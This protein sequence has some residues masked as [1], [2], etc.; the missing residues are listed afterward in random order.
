MFERVIPIIIALVALQLLVRYMNNRRVKKKAVPRDF[1]YK[2][3]IDQFLKI[4]NYDEGINNERILTDEIR[5][6]LA[7]PD[8]LLEIPDSMRD[9]RKGLNLIIDGVTHAVKGKI[10]AKKSGDISY[11]NAAGMF[12]EIVEVINRHKIK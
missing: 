3:K 10:G 4:S 9:V 8:L 12:D 5:S 7:K 1:D 2:R 6:G 11:N